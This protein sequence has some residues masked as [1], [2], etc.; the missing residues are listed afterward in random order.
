MT[1]IS[2]LRQ[3]IDAVDRDLLALIRERL[4]LAEGVRR[5]KGGAPT[6]RPAREESLV[7]DL[8]ARGS[9]SPSLVSRVWAELVSASLAVQGPPTLHVSTEGD[10]AE[11]LELVRARFGSALPLRLY[12]TS[13]GALAAA[14]GEAGSVAVVPGASSVATWW[15]ALCPGG[16]LS[17]L[18]IQTGLPRI[19]NRNWPG[20]DW[21]RRMA[22]SDTAPE[23]SGEDRWIWASREPHEAPR[24]E[25]GEWRLHATREA[26]PDGAALLG[27][28]PDPL[29]PE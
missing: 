1:D 24:A 9:V 27:I 17:H 19:R 7:R 4:E 11:V 18:K 29:P 20:D 25:A 23:P 16:A 15:S 22:V 13:S 12:P 6:W 14:G 8:I 28:L 2:D 3:R 5:A 26:P 21:P 10:R